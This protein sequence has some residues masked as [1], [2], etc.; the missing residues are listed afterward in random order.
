[1]VSNQGQAKSDPD[2]VGI[3]AAVN[4]D[5][6]LVNFAPIIFDGRGF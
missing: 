6:V 4:R 3:A 1:M 5:L 2:E